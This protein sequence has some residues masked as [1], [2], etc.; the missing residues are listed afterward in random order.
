VNLFYTA[1]TRAKK[2]LYLTASCQADCS[3]F[4]KCLDP[5]LIELQPSGLWLTNIDPKLNSHLTPAG[6]IAEIV[7]EKGEEEVYQLL[8]NNKKIKFEKLIKN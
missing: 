3:R 8:S 7:G 6:S 1:I 4:I 5:S 2:E